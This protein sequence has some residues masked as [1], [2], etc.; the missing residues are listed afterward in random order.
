M[1]RPLILAGAGALLLVVA[2]VLLTLWS[3]R[4]E[5]ALAPP[6][7]TAPQ[8]GTAA[9][10]PGGASGSAPDAPTSDEAAARPAG[11][12][13]DVVRVSPDGDAVLAGR[14]RPGA[15]VTI[16]DDGTPIGSVTADRRGE[17]VFLPDN[18]LPPGGRELSLEA[19][20][21]DG[22]P[23]RSEDVVVL[24]V[25]E[26]PE[27]GQ[28]Q[29]LAVAMPREGDGVPRLLEVPGSADQDFA[30]TVVD[31]GGGG[32]VRVSGR[33]PEELTVRVYLDGAF[34][35]ETAV[36]AR[37]EWR[38]GLDRPVPPGSYD[39]RADGLDADGNV[40]ARAQVR[41]RRAAPIDSLDKRRAVVIQPGSNLWRIARR[42]YGSGVRY[43]AIYRA[44]RDQIAD[45]DLIYPGQVFTLPESPDR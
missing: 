8:E 1:N 30:I 25:P 9:P 34:A 12:A 40:V 26:R 44:N 45:P 10:E 3:E 41:F 35:G 28:E 5:A 38:V 14:A 13:F 6:E 31:Y 11:P 4:E 39:L 22:A 20:G 36:T 7:P 42:V 23:R 33:A 37:G 32:R 17:W 27:P 29:S 19:A 18:P 43:T 2:L 24:D 16:L 21:P 15:E